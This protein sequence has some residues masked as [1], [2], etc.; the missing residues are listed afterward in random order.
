MVPHVRIQYTC[1]YVYVHCN[2]IVNGLYVLAH[3]TDMGYFRIEAQGRNFS[4]IYSQTVLC[5]DFKFCTLH[6][7]TYVCIVY[8]AR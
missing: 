4:Q 3:Y 6:V 1:T 5:M 8:V 2:N 7:Y